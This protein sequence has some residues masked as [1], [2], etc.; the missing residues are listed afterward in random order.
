MEISLTAGEKCVIRMR[1]CFIGGYTLPQYCIDNGIKKPLF[2]S[3][4]KFIQF[5]WE[6]HAQ[7]RYDKRMLPSFSM[8]D[9]PTDKVKFSIYNTIGSVEFKNFSEINPDEY[10]AI[11]LL[12]RQKIGITK[13]VIPFYSLTEYFIRKTYAE[14]PVLNF[15]QRYPKVKAFY[16]ILP[17]K[18]SR[19][20]DG[21]E[22]KE[23]LS[24]FK[25][26]ADRI[27][28]SNGEQ[29]IPTPFDQFGYTNKEVMIIRGAGGKIRT[30]LDGTTVMTD[31]DNPLVMIKNGK[32]LTAYQPEHF[33]NRIY[34]I[35]PCH[36]T[37]A[38]APFDKTIE[39]HLQRMINENNL[40]YRVENE[41]QRCAR[42]YQD[43]FYTLN[44]L[45][46]APG[47]IIFFWITRNLHPDN[48]PFLDLSDAFDP[49]HDYKKCFWTEGHFNEYGYE[50]IAKR[51]FELLTENNFFRDKE[52]NYP[53]PPPHITATAYRHNSRRA[54]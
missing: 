3:E 41:S 17:N 22:F 7:F 47:D 49:P 40:P 19:Y 20:E 53:P 44:T 35:G 18:T 26:F 8:V 52:F 31:N 48:L 38:F 14:I 4:E 42:R 24:Q 23:S 27:K 15:L 34:F 13:N 10:D 6:V 33:Q 21:A 37:G 54:A 50:L 32:R 12:T 36:F 9:L 28:A 43:M 30:N 1:D 39:S 51:F 16:T 25:D 29:H 46:P 2:V 5:M 11:I 45:D